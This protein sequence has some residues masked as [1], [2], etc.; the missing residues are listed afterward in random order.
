MIDTQG[1]TVNENTNNQHDDEID[2]VELIVNLWRERVVIIVTILAVT[3]LGGT[4]AFTQD[5]K[6]PLYE[7][8]IQLL[9]PSPSDLNFVNQIE[10]FKIEPD[11]AF[12][13]FLDTLESTSHKLLV[14]NQTKALNSQKTAPGINSREIIYPEKA[15]EKI[16]NELKPKNYYIVYT[17]ENQENLIS[18]STIDLQLATKTVSELINRRYLSHLSNRT[19][20]LENIQ[21]SNLKVLNN[22]IESRKAYVL[23]A[24]KNEISK[25]Q[26][27]LKVARALEFKNPTTLSKLAG[28]T[29]DVVNIKNIINS[30]NTIKNNISSELTNITDNKDIDES[31][32]SITQTADVK[33]RFIPYVN[34]LETKDY[35]RGAK[36]LSAEIDS[37][38]SLNN[39][40][41][42]DNEILVLEAQKD[43]LATNIELE[44]L[45]LL[46]N[47]DVSKN[48]LNFYSENI[49]DLLHAP[50]KSKTALIIAIAVLLGGMLGFFIAIGRV[51]VRKY[52]SKSL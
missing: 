4:Y 1:Y 26:E 51:M 33:E 45:N 19:R 52:N 27:A 15:E 36:L 46:A 42:F 43:L 28:D 17:D 9:V 3:C 37:L 48:E 5:S 38:K 6:A 22:R 41:F 14:S 44:N 12:S 23:S 29:S 8:K 39:V 10:S 32:N 2:L 18:L 30:P 20:E 49:G 11:E 35:L 21:R 34:H 16:A 31:K 24:R 40:T 7:A 47:H 50:Q 25:L 13:V